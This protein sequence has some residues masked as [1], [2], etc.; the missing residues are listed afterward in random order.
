MKNLLL[1]P[2]PQAVNRS[3]SIINGDIPHGESWLGRYLLKSARNELMKITNCW[4]PP[5]I[6]NFPVKMNE[7]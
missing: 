6:P 5:Q 3:L 7:A 2:I 4:F 1:T